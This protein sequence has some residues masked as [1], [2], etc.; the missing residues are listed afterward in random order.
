[1][2]GR[3]TTSAARERAK[4]IDIHKHF[5]H[6][7]VQNRHIWLYQIPTEY[8]LADL[9][10]KPLQLGPFEQCL[11]STLGEDPQRS[12]DSDYWED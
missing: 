5:A 10:T 1:L 9:L 7:A 8:Q 2:N 12:D 4:H 6:E 3:L 11:Y